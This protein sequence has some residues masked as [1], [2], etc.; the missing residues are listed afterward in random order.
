MPKRYSNLND[1]F[2]AHPGSVVLS[3]GLYGKECHKITCQIVALKID[4]LAYYQPACSRYATGVV[5]K[6]EDLQ[7]IADR[8]YKKNSVY[9]NNVLT[10]YRDEHNH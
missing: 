9:V 3:G 1:I 5:V 8:F 4:A 10:I 6:P 7:G 2:A